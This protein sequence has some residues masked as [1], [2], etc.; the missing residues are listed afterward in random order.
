MET[1]WGP[2][3]G[4][5]CW[6]ISFVGMGLGVVFCGGVVWSIARALRNE[7]A[8]HAPRLAERE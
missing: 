2:L 8:G 4:I 7:I 5:T 1:P 6:T 3:A